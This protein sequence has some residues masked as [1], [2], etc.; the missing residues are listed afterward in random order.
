MLGAFAGAIFG[1]ILSWV[2]L[3][4][5]GGYGFT[6]FLAI[7]F[8]MGYLGAW[9]YCYRAP[10]SLGECFSVTLLSVFLAGAIIVGIAFEGIEIRPKRRSTVCSRIAPPSELPCC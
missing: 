3:A 7:P 6:L 5:L 4:L 8:F 10:R 9:L 2:S 1:A